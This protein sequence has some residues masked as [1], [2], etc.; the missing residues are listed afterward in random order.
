M[1]YGARPGVVQEWT[2]LIWRLKATIEAYTIDASVA[3]RMHML[4]AWAVVLRV[5]HPAV[6]RSTGGGGKEGARR[7]R[8]ALRRWNE[9]RYDECYER[10]LRERVLCCVSDRR[11]MH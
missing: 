4:G 11:A 9:G 2:Q 6:L 7:V 10:P 1:P 8:A 5:F 3:N